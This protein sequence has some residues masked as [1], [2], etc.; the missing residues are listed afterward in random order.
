MGAIQAVGG[1][2]EQ[3]AATS[4]ST[5]LSDVKWMI[6]GCEMEQV[7]ALWDVV[8]AFEDIA[9]AED[10]SDNGWLVVCGRRE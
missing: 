5:E 7:C 6:G 9:H 3:K 4:S 2:C 10:Y 1:V 8:D